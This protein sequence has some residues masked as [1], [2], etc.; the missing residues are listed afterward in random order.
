MGRVT[1]DQIDLGSVE[2]AVGV[3]AYTAGCRAL[4]DG[5]VRRMEW[6]AA[7]RGLH[8]VVQDRGGELHETVVYFTDGSPMMLVRSLCSCP[9][10][11]EC[12]HAGAVALAG[13]LASGQDLTTRPRSVPWEHALTSLLE[14]RRQPGA[15]PRA[16]TPIALELSLVNLAG[17]YRHELESDGL[18]LELRARLVQPGKKGGWVGGPLTW[19]KLNP[20]LNYGGR[21]RAR[22]V[23]GAA[24]PAGA[25]VLLRVPGR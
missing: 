22:R 9:A 13:A 6:D 10:E 15:R 4:E 7:R 24:S 8:G 11:F 25:G 23:S 12:M 16:E 17:Q 1:L 2:D 14:A 5:A 19:A 18:A 20:G 3:P 21:Q